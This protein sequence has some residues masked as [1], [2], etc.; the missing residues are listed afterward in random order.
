M[1]YAPTGHSDTPMDQAELRKVGSSG[2][3]V[4]HKRDNHLQYNNKNSIKNGTF[5][6]DSPCYK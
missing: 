6:G 5:R 3:V 2:F 1:A 4:Q